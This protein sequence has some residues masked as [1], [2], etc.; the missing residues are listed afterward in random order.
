MAGE[1]DS[2]IVRVQRGSHLTGHQV[3]VLV[4]EVVSLRSNVLRC[5]EC[6]TVVVRCDEAGVVAL[7][8]LAEDKA[9]GG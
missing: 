7:D 5:P 1:I 4:E 9:R 8:R 2:M 6:G 3:R